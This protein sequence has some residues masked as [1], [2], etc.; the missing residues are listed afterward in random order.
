MQDGKSQ[1]AGEV[2]E[3]WL[4][5]PNV[6]KEYWGDPGTLLIYFYSKVV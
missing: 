2:G 1:P 3:I 5:G 6:M 4:R